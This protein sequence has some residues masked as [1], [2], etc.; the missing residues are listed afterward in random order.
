MKHHIIT[1]FLL[2]VTISTFA[3]KKEKIKGNREVTTVIYE[4]D[5]FTALEVKEALEITLINGTSPQVEVITDE[6]LHEVFSIEVVDGTL[7]ISTT[8]DIRSRKK[9]E[10]F[11]TISDSLQ[12]IHVESEAELKSLTTLNINKAEINVMG[13]AEVDLKIKSDSLAINSF[14]NAE[15]QYQINTNEL[16]LTAFED[17]NIK[18]N[19][20][21]TKVTSRV[22][23][24]EVLLEGQTDS[25]FLEV[26]EK[27]EF[28][29]PQFTA[30]EISVT[31]T[32]Q[33]K[34]VINATESITIDAHDTSVIN[35]LGN[36][37]SINMLKFEGEAVL[38]KIDENKKGFLKRIF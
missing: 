28:I 35:L 15:Q 10:I 12:H 19:V 38:R 23:F 34:V 29:A 4:L 27:G 6:N 24:A 31:A 9:L 25:L 33:A 2:F 3:Q 5:P 14:G 17:S 36:P 11:V 22:E 26:K 13:D 7:S 18:A 8:K 16:I 1:T 21:A 32:E 20:T 30:K 37:T